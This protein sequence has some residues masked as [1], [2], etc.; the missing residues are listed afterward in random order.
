MFNSFK[1]YF[2]NWRNRLVA[3]AEF[4]KWVGNTPILR[5]LARRDGEKIYD[6]MA[7]FVYSQTL[8]AMVELNIFVYL[9][10]GYLTVSE[11]SNKT[12][13]PEN[14]IRLLCQSATAINL[15]ER[16]RSGH[17]CLSRLGAAI[18]GIP[19]LT[20]MIRHHRLFYQD[21]SDPVGLLKNE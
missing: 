19:G 20:D 5:S 6:L 2:I 18:V 1:R 10:T 15:L 11:L 13:I 7:G 9:K 16:S 8:L 17:Y 4:Q 21:L 3:S 12:K 14:R